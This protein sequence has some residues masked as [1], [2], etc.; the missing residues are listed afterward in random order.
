MRL[1]PRRKNVIRRGIIRRKTRIGGNSIVLHLDGSGLSL[2]V[3]G[4]RSRLTRGRGLLHGARIAVRRSGLGG[5]ARGMRL[6]VSAHHGRHAFR[7]CRHLCG[8]H[9]VDHRRCLRTGRSCRITRGG[10]GLV[11]RHLIRSSV[12]HGV[13]VS[14]VRSGLRGVH[15]GIL[16]VQRQGSGLRI[17][18]AVSKRLK[19]LS[20][21]LKRGVATKRVIKRV[22]SLSSFGVRTVVSRRCVSHIAGKLPTAFRHRNSSFGLG[23]H[24]ICPRI[25]RKH[26][27][28]SFVFR[29]GHP[30]G[31]HDKRACCVSLRLNRPARDILVPGNAFFRIAKKG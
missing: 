16:L 5:R 25:H 2:R 30:R 29:N 12:C 19:L 7:R 13:R 3:L 24:G 9:L 1:D 15:G 26:F 27:H 8:R 22:G 17:G 14:R 11:A 6:S 20:T 28:A 23:I 18:T 10:R 21:R 4:T 31:V